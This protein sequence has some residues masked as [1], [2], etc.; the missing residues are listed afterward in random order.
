MLYQ[1]YK[2]Q[3]FTIIINYFLLWIS[4]FRIN[5]TSELL[6]RKCKDFSVKGEIL[7][8][9]ILGLELVYCPWWLPSLELQKSQ[10]VKYAVDNIIKA[11]FV[12]IMPGSIESTLECIWV[13]VFFT[14]FYIWVTTSCLSAYFIASNCA[15]HHAWLHE[16]LLQKS[17]IGNFTSN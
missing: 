4:K 7:I 14:P 9:L 13:L 8:V 5:S 1:L 2:L 11:G 15:C 12:S 10:P 16:L 17:L 3:Y 6:G